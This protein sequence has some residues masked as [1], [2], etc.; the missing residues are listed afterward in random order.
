MKRAKL[1]WSI[2]SADLTVDGETVG[3]VDRGV[4]M[5]GIGLRVEA[6]FRGAEGVVS[7]GC[8]SVADGVRWLKEQASACGYNV[9]E[10]KL[11]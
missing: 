9:E 4:G 1:T 3:A 10:V 11:G 6:A 2:Y 7:R 5:D 8:H